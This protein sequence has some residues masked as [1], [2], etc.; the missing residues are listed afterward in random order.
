VVLEYSPDRGTNWTEIGRYDT[1]PYCN[2]TNVS[3]AIPVGSR[4]KAVKFR[5]RQLS[6][7]GTGCDHWALDDVAIQMDAAP[8]GTP[9]NWLI[10]HGFT[11]DYATAEATDQDQDGMATWQEYVADTDPTNALS[12]LKVTGI[13]PRQDATDLRWASRTSRT[14][15][16]IGTTN[17]LEGWA[18]PALTSG[19][20]GDASGTNT[21]T[22]Q[23]PPDNVFYRIKVEQGP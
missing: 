13:L 10:T 4:G 2:W 9:I 20:P 19:V 6:N 3:L 8:L 22:E 15:A 17:L 23:S 21:Y 12:V 1:A 7:T 18:V 11:N 14:Y 5:W 16:V